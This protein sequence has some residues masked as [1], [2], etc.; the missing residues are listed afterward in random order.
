MAAAIGMVLISATEADDSQAELRENPEMEQ[1]STPA[2]AAVSYPGYINKAANHIQMNG[3]DWSGLSGLF[4]MARD[5]AVTVLHI[6]DSHLQADMATAVTRERLQ[7]QYGSRGRGL[8]IPFKLA[9]TN[10]PNDYAITSTQGVV[11]SRL[12]KM[13]WPTEMTFTGIAIE[14]VG[15]KIDL[16]VKPGSTFDR[17]TLHSSGAGVEIVSLSDENGWDVDFTTEASGKLTGVALAH[18]VNTAYMKL[19]MPVGTALGGLTVEH[20]DKGVAY[21]VIG[22]NGATFSTYSLI[23]GMG[24]DAAALHPD[25][26]ILSL[27]TNEAFGKVSDATFRLNIDELVG[28]LRAAN[29]QAKLLIV[30]P[31]ECQRK[32]SR[33]V[34]RKGKKR[35]YTTVRSYS[36]NT[37]VKR[38]RNVL[39]EYGKAHHI[40]VYDWYAV[41]GGDGSS[42]KWLADK[43]LNTDRVHLTAKGYRLQGNLFTDALIESLQTK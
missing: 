35:R 2:T 18:P 16:T 11:P 39:L 41:A 15:G 9:G 22:N 8:I 6:G 10:E 38:L 40:P 33:R 19:K 25:L 27:G 7:A 37:N 30:T 42:A 20:G 26:I 43:T 13:P 4:G 5:T 36:V 29:P 32:S 1:A 31:A 23:G 24:R 34:R 12:L 28:E 17:M 21:H 3:A 14:P